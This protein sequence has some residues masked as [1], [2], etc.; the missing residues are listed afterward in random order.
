MIKLIRNAQ[1][2]APANI[3]IK[4]VLIADGRICVIGEN[5]KFQSDYIE[6]I[7]ATGKI[8]TP[9][10][11]DSHVHICGGGGEGGFATRT[12]EIALTDIT[13]AGFTTVIGVLGT[14]GV[15]R[16]MSNLIAKA[17]GLEE[18]G[19]STYITTGSYQIPVKTLTSS[20]KEDIIFIDK[21]IG[22]GEVAIGDHR[23]SAPTADE[24]AKVAAE[25][26]VGGLL[27]G[28][29]GTV[30]VHIG[31]SQKMI[32]LIEEALENS[33]VPIKH[34]V[35]THMNRNPYL[36][37]KSQE[38]LAKGGFV[39]YTSGALPMFIEEGEIKCSTALRDAYEK[40]LDITHI[41]WTSDGQGS[42]PAFDNEGKMIGLDVGKVKSLLKELQDAVFEEGLPLEVALLPITANPAKIYKLTGKGEVK[43]GNSADI[44]ILDKDTLE[45]DTV[46]AKG[47]IMVKAGKAAVKGTFE[48]VKNN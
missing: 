5:L 20:I 10:F 32:D 46:I 22:V 15:T 38:F 24:L 28:K 40:E 18:E 26:R 11:I 21:V 39:D 30:N 17:N 1:V 4:D 34:F 35:P 47:Q 43:E 42:M 27:S 16:T 37:E 45:V 41:T 14:D 36:Y 7:D 48:S 31:D 12:P 29:A 9:G 25:A 3:G 2:Y 44:T 8:L 33:D 13:L 23:S 6:V 19:I